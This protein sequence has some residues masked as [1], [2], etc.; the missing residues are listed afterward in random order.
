[1]ADLVRRRRQLITMIVAEKSRL[2]TASSVIRKDIKSVVDLLERRVVKIDTLIDA[3]IE[4]DP[5]NGPLPRC[6]ER[7]SVQSA[8]QTHVPAADQSGK[9]TQ[10]RARCYR[11]KATDHPQCNAQGRN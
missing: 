7:P 2:D 10:G 8:S 5:E 9:A 1:M 6:L 3:A 11:T 4:S